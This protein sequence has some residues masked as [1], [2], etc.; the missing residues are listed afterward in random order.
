MSY[1]S[2]YSEKQVVVYASVPPDEKIIYI[3]MKI[4]DNK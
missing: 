3:V 2:N 4:I 1:D